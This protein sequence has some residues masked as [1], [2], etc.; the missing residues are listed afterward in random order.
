MQHVFLTTGLSKPYPSII[1][2]TPGVTPKTLDLQHKRID[3]ASQCFY[4]SSSHFVAVKSGYHEVYRVNVRAATAELVANFSKERKYI[5]DRHIA[6]SMGD[7]DVVYSLW[8]TADETLLMKASVLENGK[9]VTSKMD[10][11]GL[12]RRLEGMV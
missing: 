1:S 12:Y 9:W 6:L 7:P 5:E 8:R 11:G 4:P 3:R 10:V 2:L